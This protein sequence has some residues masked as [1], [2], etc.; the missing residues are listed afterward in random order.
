[1]STRVTDRDR[2]YKKLMKRLFTLDGKPKELTVGIHAEEGGR[3]LQVGSSNEFGTN[4]IPERS[5][6]RAWAD[7]KQRENEELMKRAAERTIEGTSP[8]KALDQLGSQFV[9]SM[10]KRITGQ[11]SP[12]NDPATIAQKGSSTPLINSGQLLNSINFKVK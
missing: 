3:A 9:A 2:G 5:F 7:D 11:I 12:P 1:M 4:R 6:V 8:E 10:K